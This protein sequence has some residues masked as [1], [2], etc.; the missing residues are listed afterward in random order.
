MTSMQPILGK[1]QTGSREE[2]SL[3]NLK[4]ISACALVVLLVVG[5][6]WAIVGMSER[7]QVNPLL[8]PI[9]PIL[10]ISGLVSILPL[11]L[12]ITYQGEFGKLNPLYPPHYFYLFRKV[13]RAFLD[14]DLKVSAKDL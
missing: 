8:F 3:L 12:Y 6:V 13:F 10:A 7:L 14:N 1:P 5:D 9:L 4:R 11:L 2:K